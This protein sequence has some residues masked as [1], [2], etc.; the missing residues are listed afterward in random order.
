MLFLFS[1]N[2]YRLQNQN[3]NMPQMM[4]QNPLVIAQLERQSSKNTNNSNAANQSN[5]Q[6]STN[7]GTNNNS[8]QNSVL[9]SQDSHPNLNSNYPLSNQTT[10][11][12]G[13]TSA[14][15]SLPNSLGASVNNLNG[16]NLNSSNPPSN[17]PPSNNPN[18]IQNTNP[19]SNQSNHQTVNSNNTNNNLNHDQLSN[20]TQNQANSQ[21]F[22]LN[23]FNN[24]NDSSVIN[25]N[26][27]NSNQLISGVSTTQYNHGTKKDEFKNLE[28]LCEETIITE[29]AGDAF[30]IEDF[31][32]VDFD[33]VMNGEFDS[34]ESSQ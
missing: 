31:E 5:L 10:I 33:V 19:N 21:N 28:E 1:D 27:S 9:Y 11:S 8:T 13:M 18:F 23:N 4:S 16:K 29:D 3:Y 26:K 7:V 12:S 34:I 6:M 22:N 25:T 24:S 2:Q 30:N 20:L 15:G 32:G 17:Q 14:Y